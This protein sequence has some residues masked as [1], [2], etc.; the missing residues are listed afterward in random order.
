[1][2]EAKRGQIVII[3]NPKFTEMEGV[4]ESAEDDRLKIHYSKEFKSFAWALSESDELIVYVHTQFGIKTMNS[5]VICA[6]STDGELVIENAA[7]LPIS[8]KRNFVRTAAKFRFFIKKNDM[9]IGALSVDISAG[10]IKFI[11]DENIFNLEDTIEIKLLSDDFTKDIT[12]EGVIINITNNTIIAKYT[13]INE[14]DRDK[15][16]GF[17]INTLSNMG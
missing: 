13:K 4:I 7:A 6:P 15:I 16:A 5:M 8:Q 3:K 2:I 17:C 10:G 9:L 12:I 11:P 14:F 1:M